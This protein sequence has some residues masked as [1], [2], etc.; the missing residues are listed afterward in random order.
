MLFFFPKYREK[1]KIPLFIEAN[2]AFI[3]YR[4]THWSKN[5]I[6]IFASILEIS[7]IEMGWRW[8]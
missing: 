2:I 3:Y 1:N 6:F 5:I 8:S 4:G 7:I